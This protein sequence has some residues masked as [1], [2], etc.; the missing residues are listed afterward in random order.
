MSQP[1]LHRITRSSQAP[2]IRSPV[3]GA[4]LDYT[5]AERQW[6]SR[7]PDRADTGIAC[8]VGDHVIPGGSHAL[9]TV[10][11]SAPSGSDRVSLRPVW[12]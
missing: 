9:N 6:L 4:R 1:E 7:K 11:Q 3:V 8:L 10:G 12:S 2:H 5:D